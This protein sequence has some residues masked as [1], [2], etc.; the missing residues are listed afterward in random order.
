MATML[1]FLVAGLVA[2][3]TGPTAVDAAALTVN[4]QPG[5][6]SGTR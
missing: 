4:L 1:A 6:V 5:E 2:L 3:C